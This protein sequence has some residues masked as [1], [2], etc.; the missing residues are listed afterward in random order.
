MMYVGVK[1]SFHFPYNGTGNTV[2]FPFHSR[3][4]FR[5]VGVLVRF[6][7]VSILSQGSSSVLVYG[8]DGQN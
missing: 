6:Q 8:P 4:N 5:A 1:K 2:P 7:T 3:L